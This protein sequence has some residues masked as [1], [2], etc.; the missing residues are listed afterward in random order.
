MAKKA[1]ELDDSLADAHAVLGYLYIYKKQHDKAIE[2]TEQAI[3]LAPNSADAHQ[4]LALSLFFAG[5]HEESIVNFKKAIRLNPI[6]PTVSVYIFLGGALTHTG[7]YEDSIETINKALRRTPDNYFAHLRLTVS[8]SLLG[9]DEEARAHAAEVLR[10][11][12]KFSLKR[13]AKVLP[14]KNK[15]DSELVINALSKAGLK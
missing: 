15:A 6:L 7:R 13:L 5:R 11:N 14:F 10:I 4:Y 2:K 3:A 9:Q 8:Y 12:R 1:I